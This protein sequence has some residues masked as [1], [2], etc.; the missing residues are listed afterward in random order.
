MEQEKIN[1]ME[2][3]IQELKD[4]LRKK[5][6]FLQN[7]HFS[8]KTLLSIS[9]NQ[10]TDI[11]NSA[12]G[13]ISSLGNA[14]KG[15]LLT[16]NQQNSGYVVNSSRNINED[17]SAFMISADSYLCNLLNKDKKIIISD[18]KVKIN[19]GQIRDDLPFFMLNSSFAI[20]P[21]FIEM[22]L[23]GIILLSD[24]FGGEFSDD[25]LKFFTVYSDIVASTVKNLLL[26]K[27]IT[28]KE[29]LEK[30]MEIASRI[31]HVLLP[32]KIDLPDY[33]S[34]AVMVSA[35]E[36]GGDFYDFFPTNGDKWL[37]MGDVSGHGLTAGLI[38]MMTRCML[39]SLINTMQNASPNDVVIKLNSLVY[40]NIRERL[41]KDEFVTFVCMKYLGHG[42]WEYA[43]SHTDL[44]IY[45]AKEKRCEFIPTIGI[46]LGVQSYISPANEQY[47][48]SMAKEDILLMYTDGAS[49]AMNLKK[50]QFDKQG[51]SNS[52]IKYSNLPALE[53]KKGIL[54]DIQEWMTRQ[55]DDITLVILKKV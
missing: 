3:E 25:D 33:D 1:K 30:E 41:K 51:L 32:D 12:L 46:W 18:N 13:L 39:E 22:E 8:S 42:E 47:R 24:K 15:I 29:R 37:V 40:S 16:L 6:Y 38:M 55:N 26:I 11:Y 19:I 23:I 5:D 44:I 45:R 50:K 49:E 48:F 14:Q 54:S 28:E 20:I 52:L 35:S 34:S 36:V 2:E 7:V 27:Q 10:S 21:L 43:G 4:K 9:L 53:I 31:Q 17:V